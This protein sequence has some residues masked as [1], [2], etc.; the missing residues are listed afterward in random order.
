MSA[1]RTIRGRTALFYLC[2]AALALAAILFLVDQGCRPRSRQALAEVPPARLV[3]LDAGHG[4]D[5]HFAL[6]R[7]GDLNTAL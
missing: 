3:I 7:A 4:V 2:A 5:H 6:Y 1:L